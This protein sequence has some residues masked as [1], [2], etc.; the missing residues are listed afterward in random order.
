MFNVAVASVTVLV[1]FGPEEE[2]VVPLVQPGV[3]RAQR[4][5]GREEKVADMNPLHIRLVCSPQL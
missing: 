5:V 3:A 1:V 2:A 4:N